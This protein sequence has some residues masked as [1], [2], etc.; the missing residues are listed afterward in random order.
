MFWQKVKKISKNIL[1]LGE[2][3]APAV[4]DTQVEHDFIK[5][6][7]QGLFLQNFLSFWIGGSTSQPENTSIP[8]SEYTANDSGIM[9]F[10]MDS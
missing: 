10:E 9:M 7:Q 3:W 6:T 1:E 5:A 2:G 4:L 8:F